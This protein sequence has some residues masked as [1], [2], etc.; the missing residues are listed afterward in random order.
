VRG[1]HGARVAGRAARGATPPRRR[2]FGRGISRRRRH[3]RAVGTW[4]RRSA[5]DA[6]RAALERRDDVRSPGARHVPGGAPPRWRHRRLSRRLRGCVVGPEQPRASAGGTARLGPRER[7]TLRRVDRAPLRGSARRGRE[8]PIARARA[9]GS[10]TERPVRP[11]RPRRGR[12]GPTR[13]PRHSR[14]R[15]SPLR[16]P[17]LLRLEARPAVRLSPLRPGLPNGTAALRR[18][19]HQPGAPR[20]RPARRV[21]RLLPRARRHGPLG[22]RANRARRRCDRFLPGTA[23]AR[24]RS[25]GDDL[26]RSLRAHL[27]RHRLGAADLRAFRSAVRRRR[28]ARPHGGTQALL[29]RELPLRR[30][31]QCRPGLQGLPP[32]RARRRGA[33]PPARQRRSRGRPALPALVE[34]AG[35]PR[36]GGVLRAHERAGE[37]PGPGA[38]ACL[39]STTASAT[40]ARIQ[41]T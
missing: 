25:P 39:R 37:S 19:E 18:R 21:P 13:A 34:R 41:G 31:S 26:R 28:P 22:K 10:D 36:S 40:C 38:G 5:G 24:G 32:T 4:R 12:A 30:R 17:R 3:R 29:G 35:R 16:A 15:R 6:P 23:H 1:P 14:L 7:G 27:G 33:A 8:L 2:R 20:S 9:A 11:L